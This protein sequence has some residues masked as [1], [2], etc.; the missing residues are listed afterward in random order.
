LNKCKNEDEASEQLEKMFKKLG[1]VSKDYRDYL[2]RVINISAV[3]GINAEN[4][5]VGI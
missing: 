4:N 1:N 2:E 3:Y 5:E